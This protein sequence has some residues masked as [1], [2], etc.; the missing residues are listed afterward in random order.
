MVMSRNRKCSWVHWLA[1]RLISPYCLLVMSKSQ[2][3]SWA[4]WSRRLKQAWQLM[5]IPC[6]RFLA[7]NMLTSQVDNDVKKQMMLFSALIAT[8]VNI[9]M[10][11]TWV[12]SNVKKQ[13]M[14]LSAL[15]AEVKTDK[16]TVAVITRQVCQPTLR[17]VQGVKQNSCVGRDARWE[18]LPCYCCDGVWE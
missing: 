10:L 6:S 13:K 1:R 2:K 5:P 7:A 17:S 18:K 14:L 4:H 9:S 3:C 8:E 11:S 15:I 12:E 16:M